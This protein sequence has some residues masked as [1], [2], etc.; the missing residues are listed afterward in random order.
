M[1]NLNNSKAKDQEG[2]DMWL[3]GLTYIRRILVDRS[4]ARAHDPLK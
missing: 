3:E 4:K 1:F 2:I